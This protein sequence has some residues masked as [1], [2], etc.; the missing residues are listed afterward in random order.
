M[1][2]K[3]FREFVH[4]VIASPLASTSAQITSVCAIALL[5]SLLVRSDYANHEFVSTNA[6]LTVVI[7][8]GGVLTSGRVLGDGTF[9]MDFLGRN[10]ERYTIQGSQDFA[11]WTPLM[12]FN[13]TLGGVRFT[14]A[15]VTSASRRFYRAVQE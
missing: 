10:G 6:S 1:K 5:S 2:L 13:N 3:L 14:D 7:P 8:Q 11:S 12:T 9:Q 15:A 4:V